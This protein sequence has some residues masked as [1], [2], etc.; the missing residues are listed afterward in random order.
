M[1]NGL[2]IRLSIKE[3]MDKRQRIRL[4]SGMAKRQFI[5]NEEEQNELRRAA[6]Q[7]QD[8]REL[9]RLQAVRLYG[10]GDAVSEIVQISGCTW[11]A[12]MDWCAAYRAAGSGGLKSTWQGENALKL[13]RDQRADLKRRLE[14]YRPD[15]VMARELR[16][17]QGQFWTISDLRSVVQRGYE[18]SYACRDSYVTLLHECRYRQQQTERVY[19]SQPDQRGV[20]DFEAR[21]EKSDRLCPAICP[22]R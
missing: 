21:L 19:R 16:I 4:I 17:S 6:G 2:S 1:K 12:L 11:R 3:L 8:S 14:A 10:S 22:R 5:V 15:H 7:T 13:S 9:R 20:T 18:V